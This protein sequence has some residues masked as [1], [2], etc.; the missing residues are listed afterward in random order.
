M[1]SSQQKDDRVLSLYARLQKGDVI[2]KTEEAHRFG[3]AEK[4]I[5]RDLDTGVR[6]ATA[7]LYCTPRQKFHPKLQV[8]AYK[9]LRTRQNVNYTSGIRRVIIIMNSGFRIFCCHRITARGAVCLSG[10]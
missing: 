10:L 9:K 1:T 8:S 7:V 3:V 6:P 5:Q 2:R 4:S